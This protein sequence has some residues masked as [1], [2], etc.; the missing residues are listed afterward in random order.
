[1]SALLLV[2]LA[3]QAHDGVRVQANL[4]DT[5]V[6]VGQVTTFRVDV[7]TDGARAQIQPLATLP[8]GMELVGTR[9]WDQ[10]QFNLPGGSRRHI[11]REFSLRAREPGRYRI[12]ALTVLVEGRVYTTEPALLTVIPAA[13][14]PG[15]AVLGEDGVVLRA[16][17]DADTVYVGQQVTLSVEA[18]FSR[19]ARLRLRRAPEYEAPAPPGF[20][21]HEIPGSPLPTSRGVRG[22]VYESQLFRRAFFA[23]AP[24]TYQIPPA[25]LFYEI[26]RGI[27]YAPETFEVMSPSI[28]LVVLPVPEEGRPAGFT[29]AVGRFTMT[30]GVEPRRVAVG[31]AA[32][33][34]VEIRGTGNVRALPPPQLPPLPGI[35]V[36]PPSEEAHVE[37]DGS[38][39][40]GWKRFTWVLVPRA[41]G[42]LVFPEV[43]Y[44]FF[45]PETGGFETAVVPP[46][47][48]TVD[49]GGAVADD[50]ERP[51]VRYLKTRP[52]TDRLAW[53]ASPWFVAAQAAP[54]LL[55]VGGFL[56]HRRRGDRRP[57][58]W[59]L[60]RRRRALIRELEGQAT[61]GGVA[62]F[63]DASAAVRS[64]LGERLDLDPKAVDNADV[65]VG[66]GVTTPT[67]TALRHALDRCDSARYAPVAPD[68]SA[69]RAL[70]R[71]LADLLD[72]V[73]GEAARGGSTVPRR[74]HGGREG[75][76]GA[77]MLLVLALS[78]TLPARGA[79]QGDPGPFSQGVER[80]DAGQYVEAAQLFHDHVRSRPDDAAG[81]YN[82]GTAYH[83]A[84][85]QGRAV[86]AWLRAARLD[87][88]DGDTRH[89]LR[90]AGTAPELVQRA[91]PLLPLRT[92]EMLLLAAL[93]WFVA[94]VGGVWWVRRRRTAT[95]LSALLCLSLAVGLAAMAWHSTRGPDTLVMLEPAPLRAAPNLHAEMLAMLEPGVGLVP[96]DRRGD[97]VRARTLQGQEGWLEAALAGSVMALD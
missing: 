2:L 10:R 67:A 5:E 94:G 27:L 50:R 56:R 76:V 39:V 64:W 87:P 70:V 22:D 92:P 61:D 11:S 89:N 30:G 23:I 40:H 58:R 19:D 7:E 73:D 63:T 38:V 26:R 37:M 60:R 65:L 54:L 79:A 72:R 29:G 90:V 9:D 83:R 78:V 15:E 49:P 55:L 80:F 16:W 46:L 62:F 8:P 3:L 93:A 24:G 12:P 77:A 86:L 1:V 14:A 91:T 31:D 53:V 20:W 74:P 25:R 33:L 47:S 21:V 36:F 71:E 35:D 48:M 34:S 17:L 88:R 68:Q 45:D 66:A 97:W 85:Q 4:A 18:M 69:R 59:A 32:V 44:P 81:W 84:G 6:E 82:L 51:V 13:T 28:P 95:G 75:G 52:A 96:M 42:D 43:R 57:G 41:R